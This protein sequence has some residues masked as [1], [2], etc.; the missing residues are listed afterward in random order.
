MR[1]RYRFVIIPFLGIYLAFVITLLY[2][3]ERSIIVRS[4]FIDILVTFSLGFSTLGFAAMEVVSTQKNMALTA[5]VAKVNRA[6]DRLKEQVLFYSPLMGEIQK[7]N[8]RIT[9]KEWIKNILIKHN[10][11]NTYYIYSD[12]GFRD[13]LDDYY[14]EWVE[15]PCRIGT[16]EQAKWEAFFKRFTETIESDYSKLMGSYRAHTGIVKSRMRRLQTETS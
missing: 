14:G 8:D 2:C 7:I 1:W 12:D 10:I 15:E 13:V 16:P 3:F 5:K 11:K 9:R 4:E 6:K